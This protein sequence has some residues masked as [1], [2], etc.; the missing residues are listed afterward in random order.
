M[1]N[2]T[3]PRGCEPSHGLCNQIKRYE[4]NHG[5]VNQATGG[6]QSSIFLCLSQARI[7]W[8]GYGR[9]GVRPEKWGRIDGG[10]LL[11]SLDGVVSTR[12][13]GLSASCYAP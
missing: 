7:N 2:P 6:M 11:I 1:V 9:K 4:S 3:K 8:D 12:I 5:V 10:G 13:V